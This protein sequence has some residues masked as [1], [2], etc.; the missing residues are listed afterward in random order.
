ML[1]GQSIFQSVLT[2]L[3]QEN[4]DDEPEETGT[5]FRIMGLG[6]G[7]V[8][9]TTDGEAV[10]G[11]GTEAYYA[12]EPDVAE[13]V[14]EAEQESVKE[15]PTVTNRIPPHL[16][17][18]HA[19]EIAADLAIADADTEVSLA[20]KRRRFAKANH[21]DLVPKEYRENANIRMTT[22]NLLIDR[23]IKD[24]FWR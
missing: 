22:A 1:F 16:L 12:F 7:F 15:M 20:E 23:A 2:R 14:W 11:T 9:S 24:R 10:S 13:L 8:A 17:R 21:P 18:L 5:D 6:V 19:D 4:E 3:N